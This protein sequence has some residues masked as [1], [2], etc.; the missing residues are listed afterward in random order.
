M[1][2]GWWWWWGG[3]VIKW[4]CQGTLQL[5]KQL[6][7]SLWARTLEIKVRVW[8][9]IR[10]NMSCDCRTLQIYGF[11]LFSCDHRGDLIIRLSGLGWKSP[12]PPFFLKVLCNFSC[13]AAS[14]KLRT[15]CKTHGCHSGR[16]PS[17]VTSALFSLFLFLRARSQLFDLNCYSNTTD[18]GGVNGGPRPSLSKTKVYKEN[19]WET[20]K[21]K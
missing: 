7:R 9:Q 17:F 16:G 13:C 2:L 8:G 14:R 15:I 5:L 18:R 19:K 11:I 12:P 3:G 10:H 1:T 6:N 4:T 21:F 20:G